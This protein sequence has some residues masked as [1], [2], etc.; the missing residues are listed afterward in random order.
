MMIVICLCYSVVKE[1]GSNFF[2]QFVILGNIL[3]NLIL[4]L[5]NKL[6]RNV[7]LHPVHKEADFVVIMILANFLLFYFLM[8]YFSHSMSTIKSSN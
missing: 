5:G 8:L 6:L 1:C 3:T 2:V 4:Y 7:V